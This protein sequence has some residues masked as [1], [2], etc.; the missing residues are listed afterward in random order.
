MVASSLFHL[1]DSS[2]LC[3]QLIATKNNGGKNT[4][5]K[6]KMTGKTRTVDAAGRVRRRPQL[7]LAH[8]RRPTNERTNDNDDL[9]CKSMLRT[10]E[11]IGN[12]IVV[13]FLFW[14]RR[15]WCVHQKRECVNDV[16]RTS[17]SLLLSHYYQYY[18]YYWRYC[19]AMKAS[20]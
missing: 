10:N 4:K 11:R 8:L 1:R 7:R 2:L 19:E 6:K 16:N 18:Y 3:E 14:Q 17:V 20:T 13:T 12:L 15:L 5:L 9:F